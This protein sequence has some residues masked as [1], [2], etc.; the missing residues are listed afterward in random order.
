MATSTPQPHV[1]T[2]RNSEHRKSIGS[3][4]RESRG[5]WTKMALISLHPP[6]FFVSLPPFSGE[7]GSQTCHLLGK[8]G[9]HPSRETAE[10]RRHFLKHLFPESQSLC[11]IME[12]FGVDVE[13]S[14]ASG[15]SR[16][17]NEGE[18][19]DGEIKLP[20]PRFE[21]FN[22]THRFRALPKIQTGDAAHGQAI[23]IVRPD[24]AQS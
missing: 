11:A 4:S 18:R 6:R 8:D 9:I 5:G 16:S 1:K 20:A 23:G 24:T 10:L 12:A 7:K 22:K 3:Q 19:D 21:Y 14:A 13:V 2:H 15:Y 17:V